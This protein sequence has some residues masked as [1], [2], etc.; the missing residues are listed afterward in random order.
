MT[1]DEGQAAEANAELVDIIAEVIAEAHL[2]PAG[3]SPREIAARVVLAAAEEIRSAEERAAQAEAELDD[4]DRKL[5]QW[6][7]AYE[8]FEREGTMLAL[9]RAYEDG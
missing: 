2:E 9:L 5:A 8:T 6:R 7:A 3:V 1:T 4:A